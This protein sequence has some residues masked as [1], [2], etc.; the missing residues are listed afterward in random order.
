LAGGGAGAGASI[1][2]FN[3]STTMVREG[4]GSDMA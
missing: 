1:G 3:G 2:A 4:P